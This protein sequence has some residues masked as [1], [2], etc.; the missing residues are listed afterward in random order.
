[1]SRVSAESHC[2]LDSTYRS[3]R[4]NKSGLPSFLR[5]LFSCIEGDDKI[6]EEPDWVP[7]RGVHVH[8]KGEHICG[9]GFVP[10]LRVQLC[11]V[12]VAAQHHRELC[13]PCKWRTPLNARS[14]VDSPLCIIENYVE[15]SR[16]C[17]GPF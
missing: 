17:R 5:L 6:A 12:L 8:A 15:R 7:V 1:M 11:D 16:V 13:R 9:L 14:R 3:G 4:R 2:Q 10:P